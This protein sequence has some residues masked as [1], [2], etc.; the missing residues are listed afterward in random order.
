MPSWTERRSGS[1]DDDPSKRS[2]CRRD[3]DRILYS[4][5]FLR[6]SGV[7]QVTSPVSEARV[8]NRL[9]HSLKV[10]QVA[11]SIANMLG[12]GTSTADDGANIDAIRT[13]ALAHDL[14]H[15]PFGH[16]GEQELH[17]LVTCD[18]H[19][20]T[21]RSREARSNSLCKECKL[22]DG[23]EGNAQT[24][25]IVGLL[26]THRDIGV[27]H[28]LDLTRSSMAATAKY[29][30][31]RGDNPSKPGKWGVYDVDAPMWYWVSE[32]SATDKEPSLGAQVMDY[33]DDITYAIHDLEDFYRAGRIPLDAYGVGMRAVVET[34]WDYVLSSPI[35]RSCDS[36][37]KEAF[38]S[39]ARLMPD[40]PFRDTEGD[41]AAL[42]RLR[43][44][45]LTQTIGTCEIVDG[46]LKREETIDAVNEVFK[47]LVWFHIID[48]PALAQL[49]VGQRK[50]IRRI[51]G[52]LQDGLELTGGKRRSPLYVQVLD[53]LRSSARRSVP[54]L[55]DLASSHVKG[56]ALPLRLLRFLSVGWEASRDVDAKYE[57]VTY[58][59]ILDY[60][61]SL[62][63]VDAFTLDRRLSGIAL[64]TNS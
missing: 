6:L 26:E 17:S 60:I 53:E 5:S 33:A 19:R 20:E 8:H 45:L 32:C 61:S 43:G 35:G 54:A 37:A 15:P 39:A 49:Q 56:R 2:A 64:P 63:D 52:A 34:F 21:P 36:T 59:A 57:Q 14:G 38:L 51:F 29:P 58:R 22:E 42:D 47:Q 24:L 31:F 13:A 55:T 50:V 30:W 11:E 41:R 9:T 16:I 4:E 27:T 18:V 23:F 62:T 46:R 28:G 1:C 25:R 3:R 12:I 7:T 10:E 48:D 44:Q 40:H